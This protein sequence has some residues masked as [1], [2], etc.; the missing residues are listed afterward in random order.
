MKKVIALLPLL[1]STASAASLCVSGPLTSYLQMPGGCTIGSVLFSDFASGGIGSMAVPAQ[2]IQMAASSNDGDPSLSFTGPFVSGPGLYL[3]DA[4]TFVVVAP[5]IAVDMVAAVSS[6][7]GNKGGSAQV[8]ATSSSSSGGQ[9]AT[10][11]PTLAPGSVADAADLPAGAPVTVTEAVQVS[12]GGSVQAVTN[13]ISDRATSD[14]A[15]PAV[16][17]TSS[18][19][20]SDGVGLPASGDPAAVPEPDTVILVGCGL[21]LC[22]LLLRYSRKRA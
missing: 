13:T 2:Q 20:A 7:A 9:N 5:T 10:Q 12:N 21:I 17:V 11:D 8:T 15:A 3:A 22:A 16:T 6:N 14:P 19:G 1:I 4:I 18:P